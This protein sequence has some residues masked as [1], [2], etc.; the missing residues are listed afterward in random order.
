MIP[1]SQVKPLL[2]FIAKP[3]SGGDY[4]IVYGGIKNK[5]RPPKLLTKMTIGEV[6]DWQDSIDRLYPSEAAGRYQIME[7][8]LRGL[9]H[10]AGLTLMH[11]F[12]E[13]NQDLL[14]LQLLKRRG[15]SHFLAGLTAPIKFA[16]SLSKEW[17]S[18]PA[19]IKDKRGRKAKGQSYYA[20]DGLNR[21]HVTIP[22]FMAA[23]DTVKQPEEPP[24]PARRPWW[25]IWGRDR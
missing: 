10:D 21:S 12:S 2:D 16:Q 18:L 7:D 5:H 9:Y 8:T 20:G 11:R 3:E 6:L 19:T 24:K 23:I 15:L 4:N 13:K 14:A 1:I 22:E 17:A 25:R